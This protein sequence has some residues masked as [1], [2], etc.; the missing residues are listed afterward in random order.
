MRVRR[1]QTNEITCEV[2][3]PVGRLRLVI[4]RRGSLIGLQFHARSKGRPTSPAAA[5]GIIQQLAEYFSGARRR[6]DVPMQLHGTPFQQRVWRALARIPYGKK[7]SYGDIAREIGKPNAARAVGQAVGSNPLP[8][9]IPCHRVIAGDGTLGGF[10]GGL[11][12]KRQLL[13]L[14]SAR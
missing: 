3:S 9:I 12:T 4:D 7:V 10:G 6:F 14:E 11:A 1:T 13:T 2:A 5:R 8:I